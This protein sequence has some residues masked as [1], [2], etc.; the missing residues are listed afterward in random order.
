MSSRIDTKIQISTNLWSK[1]SSDHHA[2]SVKWL[3]Q[4]LQDNDKNIRALV[5]AFDSLGA[6]LSRM[7]QGLENACVQARAKGQQTRAIWPYQRRLTF[8][9][10]VNAF[11]GNYKDYDRLRVLQWLSTIQCFGHH[12][13]AYEELLKCA[14]LWLFKHRDYMQWRSSSGSAMLWLHGSPG[15][16]KSKLVYVL[17]FF[18]YIEEYQSLSAFQNPC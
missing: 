12:R 13:R 15:S 3:Q 18:H 11:Q 10:T 8:V 17:S 14:G 6:R 7:E 16:G 1:K 9:K 4:R 2:A 5:S